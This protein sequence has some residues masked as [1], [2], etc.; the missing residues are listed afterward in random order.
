MVMQGRVPDPTGANPGGIWVSPLRDIAHNAPTLIRIALQ[1]MEQDLSK[2]S[3]L[4]LAEE[5]LKEMRTYAVCLAKFVELSTGPNRP[6]GE[7]DKAK[8]FKQ[9]GLLDQDHRAH[10][11]FGK[12]LARVFLGEYFDGVGDAM[13]AAD[14]ETA[15]GVKDLA[16]DVQALGD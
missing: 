12:W 11:L 1:A 6:K 9:S 3:H 13:H 16:A 14:G 10:T 5:K 15:I 8:A 7:G 2:D 4:W